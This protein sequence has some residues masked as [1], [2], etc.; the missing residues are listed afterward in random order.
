[1]D[2]DIAEAMK[3][4]KEAN[5]DAAKV[6]QDRLTEVGGEAG[7]NRKKVT[8]LKS[9]K[10]SLLG[11]L[12]EVAKSL[13][14]E[15]VKEVSTKATQTSAEMIALSKSVKDLQTRLDEKDS[16]IERGSIEKDLVAVFDGLGFS[17]P[18]YHAKAHLKDAKRGETG[19]MI[20]DK[21]ADD[22]GKSIAEKHP[23]FLSKDIKMPKIKNETKENI[24]QEL[25][26]TNFTEAEIFNMTDA[27]LLENKPA[28][29]AQAEAEANIKE[30]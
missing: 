14:V 7:T 22:L 23:S 27:E 4:F 10:E 26:K 15:D 24:G 1:M 29:L 11:L 8:D 13:G 19:I 12:G 17:D 16:I 2:M 28:I 5:S 9:E 18:E 30:D 20:G 3:L 21:F 6:V 25:P